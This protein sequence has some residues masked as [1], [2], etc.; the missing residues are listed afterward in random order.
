M[1]SFLRPITG[2]LVLPSSFMSSPKSLQDVLGYFNVVAGTERAG[3]EIC[4]GLHGSGTSNDNSS[5]LLNFAR[6]RMLRIAGS[7]YQRPALYRWTWY[8]NAGR[9][10]KEIDHILFCTRWR[11]LQNC[12]VFRNAEFFVT[13]HR[14]V[15]ATLKLHVKSKKPPRCDHTVSHLERLKDLT[16]AQE[17][18]VTVSNRFGALNTLEDP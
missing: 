15:V 13:D 1:P 7:W 16:S 8:I 11:I 18:A 3:Y 5:L 12:S 6:S 10:A 2:F 4:V 17:Y 14:F 9:L